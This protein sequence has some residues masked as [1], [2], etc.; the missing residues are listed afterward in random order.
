MKLARVLDAIKRLAGFPAELRLQ[1]TQQQAEQLQA[2]A[3]LLEAG[4][5]LA[6]A[7]ARHRARQLNAAGWNSSASS[8]QT[9]EDDVL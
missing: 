8:S 6:E 7:H 3:A 4:D 5:E 1:R 2:Q 9:T